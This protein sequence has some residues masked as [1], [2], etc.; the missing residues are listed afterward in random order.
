M[1]FLVESQGFWNWYRNTGLVQVK[2]YG[3]M[4]VKYALDMG[5]YGKRK[6]SGL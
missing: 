1:M 2:K 3:F 5:L 6:A 4:Q